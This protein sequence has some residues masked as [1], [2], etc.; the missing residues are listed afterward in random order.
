MCNVNHGKIVNNLYFVFV[1][2]I[3]PFSE[4]YSVLDK[5]K[6]IYHKVVVSVCKPFMK[7]QKCELIALRL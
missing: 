3:I 6:E 7:P 5:S 2:V 4:N 1:T